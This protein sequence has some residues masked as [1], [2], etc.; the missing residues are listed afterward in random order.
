MIIRKI[1]EKKLKTYVLTVREYFPKT[2]KQVGEKTYFEQKIRNNFENVPVMDIGYS[3]LFKIHTIRA[4]YPLWK[5][6]IDEVNK[7][8]AILSVRYWSGKPYNSKQIEIIQFDKDSGIGVQKIEFDGL[9]NDLDLFSIDR[10]P[11]NASIENLANND[12]LSLKD[13][14]SWFKGYDLTEPMAIIHFTKFRY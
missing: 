1:E 10:D 11:F 4:N 3:I 5:N 8:N 2:H 12:G 7:G 9:K 6:R 13:F 14:K